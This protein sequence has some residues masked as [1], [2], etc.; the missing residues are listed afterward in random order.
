MERQK[1]CPRCRRN[2]LAREQRFALWTHSFGT[3]LTCGLWFPVMMILMF[4]NAGKYLCPSCG[5]VCRR[6]Q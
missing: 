3:V 5:A 2:V 1:Y 6:R 4:L